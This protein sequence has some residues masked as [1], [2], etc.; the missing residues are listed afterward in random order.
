MA[1]HGNQLFAGSK[2]HRMAGRGVEWSK[3]AQWHAARGKRSSLT[4]G[5]QGGTWTW[6]AA[7][8]AMLGASTLEPPAHTRTEQAP[9]PWLQDAP[10][11]VHA[12]PLP[13]NPYRR[14]TAASGQG[15][16]QVPPPHGRPGL[17]PGWGWVGA[18]PRVT[19]APAGSARRSTAGAGRG[20]VVV[21]WCAG[22]EG[23]GVVVA[24]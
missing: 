17:A 16:A 15:K 11:T 10:G 24:T 4:R 2:A 12:C 6:Q 8:P 9:T 18:A 23:G 19:L 1:G 14:A 5:R 7:H 3:F 13:P 20:C 22:G 21:C